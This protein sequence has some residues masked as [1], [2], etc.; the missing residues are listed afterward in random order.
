MLVLEHRLGG[1]CRHGFCRSIVTVVAAKTANKRTAL[2]DRVGRRAT[3]RGVIALAKVA[4]CR[5]TGVAMR[6]GVGGG[7]AVLVRSRVGRAVRG[8]V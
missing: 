5:A 3:G 2:I 4:S 7:P 8:C 6:R 1:R